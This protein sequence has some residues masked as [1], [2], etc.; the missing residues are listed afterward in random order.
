M[1]LTI[2]ALTFQMAHAQFKIGVKG[3]LSTTVISANQLIIKNKNDFEQ[4]RLA[5]NTANYGV[6]FGIFMQ[7]KMGNFFIQPEVLFNST[8]VQYA[9]EDFS[10]AKVVTTLKKEKFNN[11]DLPIMLGLKFGPLRLQ[12]G[13]VGHVFLSSKS[14]L[15]D[16]D[17]YS[18]TFENLTWGYQAGVGLDLGKIIIDVRYEGNFKKFG[19]HMVFEGKNLSFDN[20]PSR[21]IAS[22][23]IAF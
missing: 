7:A 8:S 23:G 18:Q 6:H 11:L 22:L 1:M 4:L 20:T 12:G 9:L 5:V 17:G 2:C 14:D 10:N 16:I 15:L 21:I 19:D 3:G 13:P